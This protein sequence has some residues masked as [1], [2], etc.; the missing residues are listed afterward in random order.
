MTTSA[1]PA[2]RRLRSRRIAAAA[3][4][5]LLA[6]CAAGP[7]FRPPAVP[8]VD[9]Y[10]AT[11]LPAPTLATATELGGAQQLVSGTDVNVQWWQALGSPRLEALMV[12]ALAASPTLAAAQA[13]LRQAQ[14][15][16]AAQAGVTRYPQVDANL[17]AQRQRFNP[18]ALG[19]A[20]DARE[21]DL[22]NANVGVHYQL[23]LAGGNRRT[24]EALAARTDYQRYELAGAQLT[25]ATNIA[26]AAIRQAQLSAQLE[27]SGSIL[28]AQEQQL[29]LTRGRVRLGQAAPDEAATLQTQVEQTRANVPL[30]RQQV[31][32]HQHLLAMLAGVRPVPATCRAF[33]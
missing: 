31:Q 22:Y 29:E 26:N 5:A 20:A 7:D 1:R 33:S 25:L 3:F 32:Q 2:S 17:G 12:Q 8:G 15:N 18:A 16:Y 27:A 4:A 11:A 30:L 10:T 9:R 23:D 24:L 6:G 14:E 21:F 28:Q 13:T 19:Q